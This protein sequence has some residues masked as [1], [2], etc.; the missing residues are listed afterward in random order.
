M[1]GFPNLESDLI[2]EDVG[3]KWSQEQEAKHD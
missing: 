3:L 2:A 1:N